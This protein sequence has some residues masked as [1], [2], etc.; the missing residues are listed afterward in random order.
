MSYL[1]DKR[2]FISLALDL[3]NEFLQADPFPH[4]VI[5]DFLPIHIAE[6]IADEFPAPDEISWNKHGSG[7]NSDG[8]DFKGVKLQCSDSKFFPPLINSTFTQF[9][10]DAFLEFLRLISGK[11]HIIPDPSFNGCGLHSTGLSGRLMVHADAN[12]YPIP[13][14]AHQYLNAIYYVTKEWESSWGGNLELWDKDCMHCV[15]SIEPNFNRLVL[16][17]TNRYSYHGHPHPIQ[18]PM[19]LRRNTMAMYF[20]VPQREFGDDY[21]G[22]VKTVMWKR[23]NAKDS[24]FS[25]EYLKHKL[26]IALIYFVPPF[27][28]DLYFKLR[29][30]IFPRK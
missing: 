4:L 15:K 29:K 17:E 21:N 19:H 2:Y 11:E 6:Q 27:V 9:N 18:C 5:D 12:R 1:F 8:Y 28:V 22:H 7:A 20:Y 10:S 14:F 26:R 16:F 30:S 13:N 23:T 25:Y 24:R 3:K